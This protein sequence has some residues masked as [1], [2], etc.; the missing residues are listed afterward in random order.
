MESLS[1]KMTLSN[2]EL[3]VLEQLFFCG[4]TWD[5]DLISKEGRN[6]LVNRGM[7]RRVD[8]WQSLSD[9]GF[10]VAVSSGYGNKKQSWQNSRKTA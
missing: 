3:A 5:G 10:D 8:G 9:F 4:P 1:A 2:S 6:D 7:A